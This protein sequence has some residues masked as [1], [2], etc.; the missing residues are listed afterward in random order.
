MLL[1]CISPQPLVTTFE[2][3]SFGKSDVGNATFWRSL[4]NFIFPIVRNIARSF[5]DDSSSNSGWM[6]ILSN[7]TA[8]ASSLCANVPTEAYTLFGLK[9]R[10]ITHRAEVNMVW[11][12]I[13][14]P[15]HAGRSIESS[16]YNATTYG[17]SPVC[18]SFPP[19]IRFWISNDFDSL[20][21]ERQT[22]RN[23]K[24]VHK[25][26]LNEAILKRYWSFVR[27]TPKFIWKCRVSNAFSNRLDWVIRF[28]FGHYH[29]LRYLIEILF[30]SLLVE[31]L[32][33]FSKIKLTC[34]YQQQH[35]YLCTIEWVFYTYLRL[36]IKWAFFLKLMV[37]Q[38]DVNKHKSLLTI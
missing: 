22:I 25:P 18:A 31:A 6:L 37:L 11:W 33:K 23:V 32:K 34:G 5:S 16:K 36:W 26:A 24:I 9:A 15:V 12:S 1:T 21:I 3:F 20:V 38:F 28:R 8:V 17:N 2:F 10:S 35:I 19:A 29:I 14:E 30:W 13:M 4:E 27:P 7:W